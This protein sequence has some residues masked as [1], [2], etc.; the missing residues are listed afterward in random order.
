MDDL[1]GIPTHLIRIGLGMEVND[2]MEKNARWIICR[3]GEMP[4]FDA[5]TSHDETVGRYREGARGAVGS[6]RNVF[7]T[8]SPHFDCL[9]PEPVTNLAHA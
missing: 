7:R 5:P 9:V 3:P 6:M 8:G 2:S 1:T 4:F